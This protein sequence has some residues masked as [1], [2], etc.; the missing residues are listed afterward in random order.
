M[1]IFSF[2]GVYD[3]IVKAGHIIKGNGKNI[4]ATWYLLQDYLNGK[5][6][7]ANYKTTFADY[8]PTQ[9][10][11]ESALTGEI[12]NVSIALDE[13]SLYL[14]SLG[15]KQKIL[16][17]IMRLV[18]QGRKIKSN[19]YWMEQRYDDVH[20][21]LRIHT[22]YVFEPEK[23][24]Y[25]MSLCDDEDCLRNDHL[26]FMFEKKPFQLLNPV[27]VLDAATV[28]K[29]YNTDEVLLDEI[30][31]NDIDMSSIIQRRKDKIKMKGG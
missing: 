24:H 8:L 14:N 23:Y 22:Q 1:A 15:E 31:A 12:D 25:D 21:R 3:G 20:L 6:V 7:I 2:V 4:C 17:F 18:K 26:I 13:M 10:I 9:D 29:L 28:G 16:K 27:I 5:N 30:S 11:I 19:I